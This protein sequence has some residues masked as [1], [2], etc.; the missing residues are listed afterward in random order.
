MTLTNQNPKRS[1]WV[2]LSTDMGSNIKGAVTDAGGSEFRGEWDTVSGIAFAA[3]Q[4][5]GFFRATEIRPHDST[6][7]TVKF[8]SYFNRQISPG[9]C[10]LQLE[11]LVGHDFNGSFGAA[12]EENL[13]TQ[14]PAN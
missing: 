10:R 12:T 2:A 4:N 8:G 5:G 7:A 11:F 3:Y 14:I 1:I 13:V 9:N 6:I